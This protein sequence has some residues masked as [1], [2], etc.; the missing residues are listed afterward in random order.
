VSAGTESDA[1][2]PIVVR[3]LRKSYGK[4][5]AVRGIDLTVERG[6]VF[7]LLGPN[8]A[9]KT[10]TTEILEGYRKRSGGGVWVLGK[11][12]S[13]F[14]R[15]TRARLGIVLQTAGTDPYLTV[16]ETVD[17]YRGYYPK[18]RPRDE[19]LELVGL[20]EQQA[21]KVA[22]LSGGQRRRLDVAI[23]LAGDPEVLF[24]DEP[25]TG[26]DPAARRSA[27]QM[28][29]GLS[30]LDKTVFLTTHYMEEAQELSHRVAVMS[31]GEIIADGPISLL[32]RADSGRTV[33][34]VRL[35]DPVGLPAVGLEPTGGGAFE[36]R[37]DEPTW[38][39]H[40][41]TSWAVDRGHALDGIEVRQP[42]LEDL[43]LELTGENDGE[44]R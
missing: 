16:R 41:L 43:Y 18:P 33:I 5:P 7:A 13:R 37:T 31:R 28:V 42:S 35:D 4:V 20:Q 39:L 12:P 19:V 44:A 34:K 38:V 10:T 23:A 17:Q 29:K 25:T 26:F 27:W 14:D 15:A 3:G 30:A 40:E 24:L 32:S 11:D 1:E 21:M 8:G 6:E 36:V 22:K 9:G 2:T